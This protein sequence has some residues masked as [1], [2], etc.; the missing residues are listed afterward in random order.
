MSFADLSEREKLILKALVEYYINTAE[1]VGSRTLAKKYDI[2]LSPASI[3]N[4]MKDLEEMGYLKHPH[5]SAG[6][7]PTATAYRNYVDYLLTPEKISSDEKSL[8]DEQIG[9]EYRAIDVLLEHTCRILSN[10]SNQLSV[11]LVSRIEAAVLT[12]LELIPVGEKKLLVIL[13]VQSGFVKSIILE[14]STDLSDIALNETA[15]ILN[16]RLCGLTLGEIRRTI[17]ERVKDTQQGDPKLIKLLIEGGD[18]LWDIPD[19]QHLHFAGTSNLSKQPEFQDPRDVAQVVSLVENKSAIR[20]LLE[21]AG[22]SEGIAVMIGRDSLA[23]SGEQISVLTSS[24]NVVGMKGVIGIIGP[25]R[26]NYSRLV[27]LMDY[28]AKMLSNV[29]TDKS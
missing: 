26:M 10:L 23:A 15:Q 8:I 3:R 16:E 1:P 21:S 9:G 12:R 5:A 24:Y 25:T 22:I 19:N 17:G 4:I 27:G 6:R 20:G 2:G 28:T 11:T 13:V 7:I 18:E 14:T 29:L